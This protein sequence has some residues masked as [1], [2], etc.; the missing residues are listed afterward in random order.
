MDDI[1]VCMRLQCLESIFGMSNSIFVIN[2][3]PVSS[4][5]WRNFPV[6]YHFI[7]SLEHK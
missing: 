7:N 6:I 1:P 2:Y 4:I 3:N 5:Y